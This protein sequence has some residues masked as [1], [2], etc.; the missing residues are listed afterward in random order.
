MN[1]INASQA[2]FKTPQSF[3]FDKSENDSQKSSDAKRFMSRRLGGHI[4]PT[5]ISAFKY[6][7]S[8][9][10]DDLSQAILKNT[11]HLVDKNKVALS[12]T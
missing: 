6:G 1:E 5:T 12:V 3:K 2:N 11:R 10:D 4:D 9:Y 7:T 8:D